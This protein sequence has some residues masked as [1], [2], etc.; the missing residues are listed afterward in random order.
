VGEHPGAQHGVVAGQDAGDVL[1][2]LAGVEA[3]LLAAV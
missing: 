1:D 2:G 3:H